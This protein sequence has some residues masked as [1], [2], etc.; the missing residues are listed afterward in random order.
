MA[1]IVAPAISMACPAYEPADIV[2][3]PVLEITDT[4]F[5]YICPVPD[6]AMFPPA[7][8]SPIGEML[9]PPEI[10]KDEPAVRSPAPEYVVA[11]AMVSDV[12]ADTAAVIEI[13]PELP[14]IL[15]EPA[16]ELTG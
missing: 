10:D 5:K 13:A 11:G 3:E 12:A 15:T 4:K 7:C 1:V 16:D 8:R 6:K 14:V 9:E 2:I